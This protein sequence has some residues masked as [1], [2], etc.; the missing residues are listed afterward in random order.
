MNHPAA[1]SYITR[2]LIVV[3]VTSIEDAV[4]QQ[5]DE[6]TRRCLGEVRETMEREEIKQL[7]EGDQNKVTEY[8]NQGDVKRATRYV[9]LIGAYRRCTLDLDTH[10]ENNNLDVAADVRSRAYS[11][12]REGN[13]QKAIEVVAASPTKEPTAPAEII[14]FVAS[15]STVERGGSVTLSWQTANANTVMLGRAGTEDFRTVQA[16]GSQSLSPDKTTIYVL[17]AGRST[18]GPTK[19]ESKTLQIQV[20]ATPPTAESCSISGRVT[21]KLQDQGFTVTHVGVFVPGE[22]KPKFQRQLDNTGRYSFK[23]LPGDQEFRVAPF[24]KSAAGW[25]Y[26]RRK[27]LVS[28]QAGGSFTVNLH[29]LGVFVD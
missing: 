23:A 5:A 28:C 29:I 14:S 4:A 17:M 6:V 27:A 25:R 11:I 7:A 8:C 24:G 16:S 10:I 21:G 13:L 18:T 22:S 19:M 12:C 2:I 3:F 26:D 20:S 15:N 9:M 1:I